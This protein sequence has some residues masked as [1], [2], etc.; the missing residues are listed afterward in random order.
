MKHS[1]RAGPARQE[2]SFEWRGARCLAACVGGRREL[3]T[4]PVLVRFHLIIVGQ[5]RE[6]LDVTAKKI[7]Q[8][9]ESEKDFQPQL[10]GHFTQG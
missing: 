7:R 10:N 4:P 6:P 5:A 3:A 2:C 8:G 1:W 9:Y